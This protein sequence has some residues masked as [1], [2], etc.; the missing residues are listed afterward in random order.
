MRI[1]A[2]GVLLELYRN[3]VLKGGPNPVPFCRALFK[4]GQLYKPP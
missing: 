1:I 2:E 4:P 3:Q